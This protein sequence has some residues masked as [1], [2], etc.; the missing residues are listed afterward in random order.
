VLHPELRLGHTTLGGAD[1]KKRTWS[2]TAV[3]STRIPGDINLD[4][5]LTIPVAQIKGNTVQVEF[6]NLPIGK[7]AVGAGAAACVKLSC[8][9]PLHDYLGGILSPNGN[10]TGGSKP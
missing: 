5:P 9:R 3:P 10:S 1:A 6:P 8:Y 4:P 7:A 2:F